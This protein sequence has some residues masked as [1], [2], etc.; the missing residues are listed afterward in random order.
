MIHVI[1]TQT[2]KDIILF[3]TPWHEDLTS[4]QSLEQSIIVIRFLEQ[5]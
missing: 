3:F 2:S 1:L 4:E 5:T